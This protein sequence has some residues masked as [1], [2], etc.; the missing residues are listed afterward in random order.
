MERMACNSCRWKTANQSKGGG[1]GRK[2][3]KRR[4]GEGEGCRGRRRRR[5][6]GRGGGRM[7]RRRSDLT[8][9]LKQIRLQTPSSSMYIMDIE[10]EM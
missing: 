2:R 10:Y 5:R 4:R 8:A 6:M 7:R 3:R 1:G 9:A